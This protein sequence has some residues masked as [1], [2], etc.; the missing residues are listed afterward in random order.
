MNTIIY[1][2]TNKDKH[3]KAQINLKPYGISLSHQ[4]L[5]MQEMQTSSGDEIVRHKAEQAFEHFQQP[6]L[7]NDDSWSIPA[8]GGFPSTGMKLCNDFLVAEDWLRL[9]KGVADRRIFLLSYY[10]YYDGKSIKTIMGRD[11]R[12]FLEK[13]K[14]KHPGAPCLEVVARKNT[15]LSIAEE[16]KIGR[17]IEQN[18]TKF[19][20]KLAII[21]RGYP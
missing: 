17:R 14:G 1:A 9:M 8:L 13:A 6:V 12:F 16:I 2:T 5:E 18:K 4:K 10:A 19:W 11:E 3:Y 21:L 15:H 7:V 20:K